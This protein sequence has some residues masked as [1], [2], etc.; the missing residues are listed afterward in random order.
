MLIG[1]LLSPDYFV[2]PVSE[3]S[4]GV[5]EYVDRIVAFRDL[6]REGL[7]R[8]II[9]MDTIEDLTSANLYP[10]FDQIKDSLS[11]TGVTEL[12]ATDIIKEVYSLL[13]SA[14]LLEEV[15]DL[16]DVVAD[17]VNT[18]P[19][20]SFPEPLDRLQDRILN[21]FFYV[22]VLIHSGFKCSRCLITITKSA[23]ESCSM[24]RLVGRVISSDFDP[25]S[26]ESPPYPRCTIDQM[27]PMGSGIRGFLEAMD[28]SVVWMAASSAEE[29]GKVPGL[30]RKRIRHEEREQLA[31]P[32]MGFGD[33][34]LDSA[35]QLGFCHEPTKARTLMRRLAD[36]LASRNLDK[37]HILRTGPGGQDPPKTRNGDIA[38]RMDLDREFHL[39]FWRL[40]S[41]GIELS[42]VVVHNDFS[43]E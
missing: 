17:G 23:T 13:Q 35:S 31:V 1:V 11:F 16:M 27:V 28:V 3:S 19:A 14:S 9:S 18:E 30:L 38:W 33:H 15:C 8:P 5:A 4:D 39:H 32:R 20:L 43:I 25:S 29:F 42:N 34:F 6:F 22:A 36:L 37:A 7:A 26:C 24:I 12:S 2:A 40:R 41:G 21:L 10:L